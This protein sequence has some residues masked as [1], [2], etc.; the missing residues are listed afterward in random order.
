MW[1]AMEGLAFPTA[2]DAVR[3]AI[4]DDSPQV[5]AAAAHAATLSGW[6]SIAAQ[7]RRALPREEDPAARTH[8]VRALGVVGSD[9]DTA[10]LEDL[11]VSDAPRTLRVAAIGALSELGGNPRV[12]G[13]LLDDTDATVSRAAVF[14][15]DSL[16]AS[17]RAVLATAP[18]PSQ[19][20]LQEMALAEIYARR[21]RPELG[22][23]AT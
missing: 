17:G 15:L 9:R 7:L 13:L 20:V 12:L 2:E 21:R 1:V 19:V 3:D 4:T 16:G 6:P 14:A 23:Q 11:V 22:A 10:V 18:Q 8:Q 5:R